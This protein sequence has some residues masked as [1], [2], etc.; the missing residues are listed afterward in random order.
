MGVF[1]NM[2]N[3]QVKRRFASNSN[4]GNNLT[5]AEK[6]AGT[7]SEDKLVNRAYRTEL[8]KAMPRVNGGTYKKPRAG[9]DTW[10]ELKTKSSTDGLFSCWYI[11]ENGNTINYVSL[12]ECKVDV[13]FKDRDSRAPVIL[14]VCCYLKQMKNNGE[15]PP[16]VVVLGSKV[17]CC[18]ISSDILAKYV[19]GGYITGLNSASTAYLQP[20]N[21]FIIKKIQEDEELAAKLVVIPVDRKNS[22][23]ELCENMV[24]LAQGNDLTE[25]L[26]P[27]NLEAFY[28][29]FEDSVLT[30]ND[31]LNKTSR[32]K[33]EIFISMFLNIRDIEI[34]TKG[35]LLSLNA[36]YVDIVVNG[37][38][39]TVNKAALE[40]LQYICTFR[41]YSKLEQKQLTGILDH[42]IEGRDRRN[43]GDYYTPKIWVDEAYKIMDK[44]LGSSWKEDYIV[45]DCAWGTGNLTRDY[46]FDN[47]FCST[48]IPG[49]LEIGKGYNRNATKFQ[50]DFLNDDVDKFKTIETLIK[51]GQGVTA[52]QTLYDTKLYK[53]A[54]ELI[55]DMF[56][57]DGHEQ[58]KVLFIINPPYK[59]AGAVVGGN[60]DSAKD[61]ANTALA[62]D[63][64]NKSQLYSQFLYRINNLAQ[65][66]KLD[67][68]LALFCPIQVLN[69]KEHRELIN[70]MA[71]NGIKFSDGFMIKGSNFADV[72]DKWSI[73]FMLFNKDGTGNNEV[74]IFDLENNEP[75][76]LGR[77]HIYS[78]EDENGAQNWWKSTYVGKKDSNTIH[79]SDPLEV[80]PKPAKFK[81]TYNENILGGFWCHSN[82]VEDNENR[83]SL[84]SGVPNQ[85]SGNSIT[86]ETFDRAISFFAARRL[87]KKTWYNAAD[88]YMIPDE[89]SELYKQWLDDCL[90]YSLFN[91]LSRQTSLR[92]IHGEEG[93]NIYNNFFFMSKDEI[94][95]L[96]GGEYNKVD[97]NSAIEDDIELC[98]NKERYMYQRLQKA[99][100][101][102]D[103][104]Q[105]LDTAREIVKWSFKY[106]NDFNEKYPL[107][108][109]NTWDAGWWQIDALMAGIS[110]TYQKSGKRYGGI[111]PEIMKAFDKMYKA[112]EDRMRPLVYELGFLYK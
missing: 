32:E 84:Y 38:V 51:I 55:N 23:Y 65:V 28:G 15:I 43:K 92:N 88:Q 45:W 112:F 66:F 72:S 108:Q 10:D 78:V 24:K 2:E 6:L 91:P 29:Y 3:E 11:N 39:V 96:A 90:V 58:K 17:N 1:N 36:T 74:T 75:L 111:N 106:R 60:G 19:N 63:G 103:A 26:T 46:T 93:L 37:K 8:E 59:K 86:P 82:R 30:I 52:K 47:L 40:Q 4:S 27:E 73:G 44:H 21:S 9:I 71:T 64:A 79:L 109:I 68:T 49:D 57:I 94:A 89:N 85:A 76:S 25:D 101:S 87:I 62:D 61:V 104:K 54:P 16:K 97:I 102:P 83:V 5:F 80:A 69:L 81:N 105:L 98:G 48:L 18:A 77:K 56:G 33:I 110:Q 34:R 70:S 53:V 20:E 13:N 99:N 14:Q 31:K 95:K 41:E 100:L 12:L 50:Y 22:A 42:L 35:G 107:V 7:G 67:I